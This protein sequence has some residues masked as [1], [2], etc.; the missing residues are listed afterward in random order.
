VQVGYFGSY[1]RGDWGV[2]SD[3]DLLVILESSDKP[4][5]V[6]A[7]EWDT[8]DI[9]VSTDVLVYTLEEWRQRPRFLSTRLM[10]E[11]VWLAGRDG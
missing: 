4:F 6:R 2:G 9:P 8:R 7:A 11:I 5:E 10:A 3:L 1:A